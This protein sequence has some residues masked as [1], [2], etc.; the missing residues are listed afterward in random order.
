MYDDFENKG[1]GDTLFGQPKDGE[2][3]EAS[4]QGQPYGA[5]NNPQSQQQQNSQYNPQFRQQ[6][7][8]NQG[9]GYYNPNYGQNQYQK[10][11]TNQPNGLAIAGMIL[12]ILSI[13]ASC[14]YGIGAL[15][16]LIGLVLSLL[17]KKKGIDTGYSG[18][19][20]A[21]IVTS[22]IGIIIAILFWIFIYL[23]VFIEGNNINSYRNWY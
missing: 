12:G 22:V 1:Q 18:M 20:I 4:P 7:P 9:Q 8:P 5:P 23:F 2:K 13:P 11:V 19:A 6:Y 3:Q 10:P 17:S 15:L 16:G 21:G 14:C